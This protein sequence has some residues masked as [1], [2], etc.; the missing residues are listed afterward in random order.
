[1]LS[2]LKMQNL[3]K[4]TSAKQIQRKWHLYDAQDKIVGRAATEIATLLMGKNKPYFVKHLDCGDYVVVVNAGQV[5]VTGKKLTDKIYTRFSGYPGGLKRETLRDLLKRRP[6]EAM[7]HAVA[8][9]LPK[10]K[11]RDRL[12]KRLFIFPGADHRYKDKFKSVK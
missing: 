7:R 9:M 4:P 8:G 6:T 11:L 2:V 5:Q 12:L 1:M 10:N 3:T